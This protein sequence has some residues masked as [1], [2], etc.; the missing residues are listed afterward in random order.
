MLYT[1]SS[2]VIREK[3]FEL[4]RRRRLKP[5]PAPG[6]L[7]ETRN[8]IR[9]AISG[10]LRLGFFSF[11]CYFNFVLVF[12]FFVSN[13]R[14]TSASPARRKSETLVS[15]K[16]NGRHARRDGD[17]SESAVAGIRTRRD[18]GTSGI[19]ASAAVGGRHFS[20]SSSNPYARPGRGGEGVDEI[21]VVEG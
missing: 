3:V 13:T 8:W 17:T 1:S 2:C 15:R 4:W 19:S 12:F 10:P 18:G 5:A 14:Y 9:A 7:R 11:R 16:S 6:D 20:D 21:D